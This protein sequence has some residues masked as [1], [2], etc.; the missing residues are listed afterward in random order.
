MVIWGQKLRQTKVL[1]GEPLG[2]A[3][4]FADAEVAREPRGAAAQHALNSKLL[5]S[6]GAVCYQFITFIYNN[7]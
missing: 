7:F 6:P 1:P 3:A 4:G 5:L 2:L